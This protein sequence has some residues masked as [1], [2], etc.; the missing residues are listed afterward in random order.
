MSEPSFVERHARWIAAAIVVVAAVMRFAGPGT[1]P[2]GLHPD[3]ASNAWNVQCLLA[4]GKD[5]NGESWPVLTSRGFGQGQ[6]TLFYYFLLPFQAA[7][8]MSARTTVLPSALT[9]TLSVLFLYLAGARMFGKTAGL[10]AATVLALMPWHLLLSRWGQES[11]IVPI[12]VTL[13]IALMASSGLPFTSR[14]PEQ[15]SAWRST[16]AGFAAGLACY[17]Y[18][19]VR[20]FLPISI[21]LAALL[22]GRNVA[23]FTTSRNGRRALAGFLLGLA[24]TLGPLATRHLMDPTIGKRAREQASWSANDPTSVAL[25]KVLARYPG[26]LGPNFLFV[27]GDEWPLH[28][29][30]SSGPLRDYTA[31]L[32]LAGLAAI[33]LTYRRDPSARTLAAML[34]VYPLADALA[35]HPSPHLLR[36]APGMVPL[37]LAA[38][39]GAAWAWGAL[40]QRQRVV[41]IAAACVLAAW[42]TFSTA[43][44]ARIFYGPAYNRDVNTWQYFN[45]DL[46]EAL[47]WVKPRFD[48]ADGVWI[49]MTSSSAME[50]P[51]VLALVEL[52]YDPKRWFADK[53][54]VMPRSDTD[55]VRSVGKIHF[56]FTPEDAEPLREL[57][58]DA[59]QDHVLIIARP[60]EWHRGEPAHTVYLP[61]GRPSFLIYDL[62]L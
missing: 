13:P 56:I 35:Q 42:A 54:V 38:G 9:G 22:N 41:A 40:R 28:T 61:D 39:L 7:F 15:A 12:L 55:L 29:L 44:F 3:A 23:R 47:D 48:G 21:V 26:S 11:G 50:Q 24:V 58:K 52:G 19:A 51:F 57:G 17:G 8:G 30:P 20:V 59:R 4:T 33:V 14:D 1:A 49:S 6:S 27:H 16:V 53:K 18:L 62:Q 32:L 36:T 25:G 5:W 37:A 34:V 31:P 2:P 43:R 45:V 10:I 60:G 46:L